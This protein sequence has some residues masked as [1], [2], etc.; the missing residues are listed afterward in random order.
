M[1]GESRGL[2]LIMYVLIAVGTVMIYSASGVYADQTF[3]SATYF[4]RRQ[5]FY[6]I[7]GSIFF[8]ASLNTNPDWLRRHARKLV[9]LGFGLLL[10]VYMPV[11][12][13]AAGGAR[14]WLHISFFSFQPV[15]FV[16]LALCLY[17]ADYLAR[18]V[19]AIT[20]GETRVLMPPIAVLSLCMIML[21]IQPD[22]GSC[23]FI[24]LLAGILFF[25]AGIP[26]RYVLTVSVPVL[27]TVA[28]LIVCAP[29]RMSRVVA[30]LN[31]WK[32]PRGSGF[33]IIQ[34]FLAF[35]SGGWKGV[36]LGQS[37]QKLFYLPQS[38]TDFIFSIVG[39]ELGFAG[40]MFV[41]ILY[42]FF[43]VL[44]YRIAR[45]ARDP[46]LRLFSYALSLMITLQAL[47]HVLVT[48]GLIPTKGLPLPF[49]SYG[50][51][52]LIF[53]MMAVGLLVCVDRHAAKRAFRPL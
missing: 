34:S 3:E 48:T 38:Y 41:L 39:E 23:L 50:G 20:E 35:A 30:Y 6:L 44:G 8:T 14:R 9:V 45:R 29:Y 46:F 47:L 16:K 27:V 5:L 43:C 10:L 24:L 1:S 7:L 40:A 37:T 36:G 25:L 26:L 19:K 12:G 49:V 2:I 32:D 17:L 22:L 52:A 28:F 4:L 53:N 42:G 11:I 13:R 15:E 18:K 51:S 33:Q 21:I 31:P